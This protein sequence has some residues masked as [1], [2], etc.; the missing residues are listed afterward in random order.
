MVEGSGKADALALNGVGAGKE[1]PRET[2]G[3]RSRG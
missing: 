2:V 1:K 3:E